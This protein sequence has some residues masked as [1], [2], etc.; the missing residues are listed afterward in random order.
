MNTQGEGRKKQEHG[1]A[2]Y[3]VQKKKGT[4]GQTRIPR[5]CHYAIVA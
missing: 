5:L 4:G 3:V 2:M 1:V